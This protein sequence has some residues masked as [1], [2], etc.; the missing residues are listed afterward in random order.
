M[1]PAPPT[2]ASPQ[3]IEGNTDEE[4]EQQNGQGSVKN[5]PVRAN[6]TNDANPHHNREQTQEDQTSRATTLNRVAL[7]VAVASASGGAANWNHQ[8]RNCWWRR[9]FC[10]PI[11]SCTH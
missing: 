4:H 11:F 2:L 9:N 10:A 8:A 6:E 1:H 3:P 7:S 5:L